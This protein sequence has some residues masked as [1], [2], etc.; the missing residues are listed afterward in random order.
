MPSPAAAF[1]ETQMRPGAGLMKVIDPLQSTGPS[2]R[3]NVM[4]QSDMEV[5]VRVPRAVLVGATVHLTMPGRIVM[6]VVRD[7]PALKQNT[8]SAFK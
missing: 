3:V 5:F 7:W 8:R 6:G 1:S 2:T 4:R